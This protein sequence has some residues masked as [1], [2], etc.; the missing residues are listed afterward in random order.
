MSQIPY[1]SDPRCAKP[2]VMV[3]LSHLNTTIFPSPD[4]SSKF[5]LLWRLAQLTD[6]L[7]AVQITKRV[8]ITTA[9]CRKPTAKLSNI[10][11]KNTWCIRFITVWTQICKLTVCHEVL[12]DTHPARLQHQLPQIPQWRHVHFLWASV[13]LN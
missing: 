3:H 4:V 2:F 5:P 10:F 13:R 6:Y 7:N 12:V 9:S 1:I 8:L 11:N